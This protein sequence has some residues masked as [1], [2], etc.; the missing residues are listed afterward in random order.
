MN[1]D[2]YHQ[3]LGGVEARTVARGLP[4]GLPAGWDGR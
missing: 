2:Y 1:P 3:V 4:A